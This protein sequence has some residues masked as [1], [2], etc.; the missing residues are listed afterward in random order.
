MRTNKTAS[1]T[2]YLSRHFRLNAIFVSSRRSLVIR[3]RKIRSQRGGG[4]SDHPNEHDKTAK[5]RVA[6]LM[7]TTACKLQG[8]E[9]CCF[10]PQDVD[11]N[12]LKRRDW[13]SISLS[14]RNPTLR[15]VPQT[16]SFSLRT[17]VYRLREILSVFPNPSTIL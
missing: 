1:A 5:K 15:K 14:L 12:L 9:S 4:T 7:S 2:K 16:C 6:F 3:S 11:R 10:R 8:R 13:F 17:R